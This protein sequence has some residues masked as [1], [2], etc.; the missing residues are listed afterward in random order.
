M[1][2]HPHHGASPEVHP[3]AWVAPGAHLIGDVFVAEGASIWFNAVLRGDVNTIRVGR[4][5]NIQDGTVIHADGPRD[6]TGAATNVGDYVTVGHACILH[7]CTIEEYV[8]IGMGS[9]VMNHSRI[10]AR[11][12][13]GARALVSENKVIPG[14]SLVLGIPGKVIRELTAEELAGRDRSA[15]HY[16]ELAAGY[17]AAGI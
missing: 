10:G 11:S 17:K 8:L 14:G 6:E 2:L 12:M 7:G 4:F 13:L 1:A 5:S 9:V 15:K 3:T 16:A